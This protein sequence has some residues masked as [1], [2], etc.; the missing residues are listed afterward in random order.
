MPVDKEV[1]LTRFSKMREYL[2]SIEKHK[3]VS[4]DEYLINSDVQSIVERN[5]HLA[6][7]CILDIC[8]HVI[9]ARGFRKPEDNKDI[10]LILAEEKILTIDFAET[11]SEMAKFRNILVHDYVKLDRKRVYN[12]IQSSLSDFEKFAK[13]IEEYIGK[14]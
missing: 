14:Q 7:E 6:L 3:K 4:L 12:I 2:K 8:N 9:S 11:L 13:I 5:L 10:P 1:I